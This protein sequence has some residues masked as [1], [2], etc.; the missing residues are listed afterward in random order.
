MKKFTF[1]AILLLAIGCDECC[2]ELPDGSDLIGKWQVVEVG[3]S[4]GAGYITN[5]V[6]ESRFV[7][8]GDDHGFNS[9]YDGLE[10]IRF[11]RINNEEEMPVLELFPNVPKENEPD[12]LVYKYWLSMDEDMLKLAY[13]YCVEGCHIGIRKIH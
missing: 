9:N 4:P 13:V 2:N 11:Y 1:I 10:D 12:Q 5:K 6:T 8:F 3:F 7:E